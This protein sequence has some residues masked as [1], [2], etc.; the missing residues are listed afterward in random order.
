MGRGVPPRGGVWCCGPRPR[1]PEQ[2]EPGREH[3]GRQGLARPRWA[4]P[5][6]RRRRRGPGARQHRV[7][8]RPSAEGA[9]CGG[10]EALR[11]L[12]RSTAPTSKL[13]EAPSTWSVSPGWYF[14]PAKPPHSWRDTHLSGLPAQ[15]GNPTGVQP[16]ILPVQKET[17]PTRRGVITGLF[18][19]EGL[20]F[21][22]LL[23]TSDMM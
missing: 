22:I 21:P 18:L 9:G 20:S 14:I 23:L 8:G 2:G 1:Q 6:R 5:R 13:E 17:L 3:G 15:A 19:G 7:P 16:Q 12:L 10:P 4:R 11:S